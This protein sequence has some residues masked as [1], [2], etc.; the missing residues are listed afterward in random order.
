MNPLKSQTADGLYS[1][2]VDTYLKLDTTDKDFQMGLNCFDEQSFFR[3]LIGFTSDG[4]SVNR[5]KNRSVKALLSE[6]SPWLIFIWRICYRLELAIKDALS[7]I[8]Y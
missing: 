3:K 7:T 2:I 5:G 1:A 4:A 8:F 6:H